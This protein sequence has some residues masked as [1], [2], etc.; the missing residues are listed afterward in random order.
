MLVDSGAT[1]NFVSSNFITEHDVQTAP[2]VSPDQVSM[3]NGTTGTS[4]QLLPRARLQIGTYTDTANFHVTDLDGYDVVLGMQW[5]TARNPTIHWLKRQL[6]LSAGGQRHVLLP[7]SPDTWHVEAAASHLLMSSAQMVQHLQHG[8]SAYVASLKSLI[9]DTPGPAQHDFSQ[10]LQQYDSSVF[11]DDLPGM[12]PARA[13]DHQIDTEPGKPAPHLPLRRMSDAEL[14]ELKKQLQE[15]LEKGFIRPSSS[16][17]GAPILFV[18]KKDG[19]MRMCVDYRALNTITV[20]NRYPLPRIDEL[21]DRLHGAK[22]FSKIDLRNGYYQIRVAEQDIHKTAFRTRYG[23]YEFTVMPFGLCNAPATFQRLVNDIFAPHLDS[24]VIVYLDDI[25]VYSKSPEEH[26]QHL[27]TVLS[28][29]QRHQLYAKQSKCEFGVTQTEFLGH[30]VSADGISVDPVKVAAVKDWPVPSTVKHVRSFLGLANYYRRFVKN[31]SSIAAP[32]T[33][34]TSDAGHDKKGHVSWGPAQQ[35]AFDA[36]KAALTS[37]P[38]LTAPDPAQPFTLRCD[39]SGVG[40]GA[41]LS[42]GS[43]PDEKVVAYYSRKLNSAEANYPVHEQELLSLLESLR[44]WRHYLLGKT[45]TLLTDNWANKHLQTQPHLD[46]RRQARWMEELQE[47]EFELTHIPGTQN[48][49]ADALSRRPD[50][51]ISVTTRLRTRAHTAPSQQAPLSRP[52]TKPSKKAGHSSPQ[53]LKKTSTALAPTASSHAASSPARSEPDHLTVEPTL[54]TDIEHHS[55]SDDEYQRVHTAVTTASRTDFTLIRGL[56]YRSQPGVPPRLYVPAGP[57]RARLL[58]EAHDVS[59]SGHLGRDKTAE[60]LSRHYYW[61]R[62]MATVA[63]YVRSC[64]ACQVHKA[65]TSAPLG[66]LH[67]LP[68]PEHRWESVSMDFIAP[69]STT[70][71]GHD[72]MMVVV[73]RLTK[74]IHAIPTTVTATAQQV[75]RLYFD[76]VFR[77]HGLP[78]SVVSDRDPKFTSEFWSALSKL[79]GT[80]LAMSTANHPQTDGQTE[81]A[82]RTLIE[83]LRA[84]VTPHH[85]DWDEWL[86]P[87]EFAYNDSVHATTGHTPFFLNTGQHP[88]TPLSLASS[89]S[90][91]SSTAQPESA[92]AFLRRMAQHIE[93]ARLLIQRAQAKQ[94]SQV[95]QHRRDH[96]FHKGD[97]VLLLSSH[98]ASG[99]PSV[100]VA[101]ATRKLLP[102]AFGPFTVKEV[103]HQNAVRLSFPQ[104]WSRAKIHPVINVSHVKPWVVSAQFPDRVPPPPPPLTHIAGVPVFTIERFLAHRVH[105]GVSQ[106][107]VHWQ[108]YDPD[109]EA[110]W[111]DESNLRA[112]MQPQFFNKLLSA[113]QEA[114]SRIRKRR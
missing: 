95:N 32:L 42:Q 79:T 5:L 43:G 49:V 44:Q 72:A 28:L 35:S 92:E 66:L 34:L 90:I 26:E 77:L 12:P 16:Q 86:T 41:V 87:V 51:A 84:Y 83:M 112:D 58:R 104:A 71:S 20:K 105:R 73:D 3:A 6:T 1:H 81:R 78:T 7:A 109:T 39:A 50:Y 30:I 107:L 9:S 103:V 69:L 101:N 23:H 37:A 38:I 53:Q 94:S 27:N 33:H 70:K 15:L 46:P 82:N 11:L 114:S 67:P 91:P 76:N 96:T 61:P 68:A 100:L 18:K 93:R 106:Y 89:S 10:V 54:L 55:N 36:I 113:L 2:K 31:F 25:L 48:V 59:V 102:V 111:E 14:A 98:F 60:R 52:S 17:Y 24:F 64:P 21:L 88:H 63:E 85:D 108:G 13:V 65:S 29:L 22:V 40:I 74:M 19:T 45:F 99:S 47:Y 56:L 97:K 110:T 8:A 75:A 57:L 4:V 80:H 62:M